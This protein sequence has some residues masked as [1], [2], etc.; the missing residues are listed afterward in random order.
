MKTRKLLFAIAAAA[1]VFLAGRSFRE[2][3]NL[4]EP[5]VAGPMM[6]AP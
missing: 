5:V 4:K 3:R 2:S 1:L 6:G